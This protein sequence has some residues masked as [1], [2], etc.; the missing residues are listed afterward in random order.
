M[1]TASWAIWAAA[2]WNWSACGRGRWASA[3]RSRSAC[4]G[5]GDPRKGQA[6]CCDR[7]VAKLLD[8]RLGGQK[9]RGC[10]SISSAD[11]GGRWRGSTCIWRDYPLPVIQQ[12]AMTRTRIA[13]LV[14]RRWRMSTRDAE[15][16]A[17][18]WRPARA[19]LLPG[20]AL[21]LRLL[22]HL[23]S[24]GDRLEATVCAR[25]CSRRA[26]SPR[27]GAGPADRRTREEGRRLAASPS[28]VT[29]CIAGSTPIFTGEEPRRCGCG[30]RRACSPMS[31][32]RQSGIPRRAR[33]EIALHGNGWR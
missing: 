10:R 9:G 5:R 14:A 29:C 23:G 4:C 20:A 19:P 3:S 13:R 33:L 11:R 31:A 17:R 2:A 6:A 7:R 27:A 15:G 26:G 8:G 30:T 1:P 32:G 16:G 21:L 25:G 18:R 12:Y 28:M 22:R 24:T